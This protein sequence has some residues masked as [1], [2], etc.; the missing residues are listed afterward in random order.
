MG[1]VLIVLPIY[2]E[3]ENLAELLERFRGV[4]ARLG[5]EA[6]I[7]AVNDGSTDR[8][9]E[10]L[11]EA[12]RGMALRVVTH[13]RNRGLGKAIKTGLRAAVEL[14]RSDDDV[15]VNMDADNTHSPEYIPDMV[16][17]IRGGADVVIASRFREG[18][19]EVGVPLGRRLISWGA[20]IV[21]RVFLNLPG[22]R[23]YTCGYRA[24]RAGLVRE[25][26]GRFGDGII[27][28]NGFACTD[29]ILVNLASLTR[30]IAEIPFVLRYDRKRGRSK[31]R[32]A[33][34]AWETLKMLARNRW[35]VRGSHRG[36]GSLGN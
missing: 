35:G 14:S 29:E 10:I 6:E 5:E 16:A 32:L 25:A 7:V 18:S 4:L 15:I 3:G 31:M 2:N 8:T 23:D 24:Y 22:V 17:K 33:L 28:R 1:K 34:T 12:S 27:T 11:S 36:R 9:G 13:E 20:R 19:K 30:K 26:L 21:F